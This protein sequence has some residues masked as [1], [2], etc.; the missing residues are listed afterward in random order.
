MRKKQL[1]IFVAI[2]CSRIQWGG[3]RNPMRFKFDIMLGR[4]KKKYSLKLDIETTF[5]SF[6]PFFPFFFL[7]CEMSHG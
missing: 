3:I 2:F 5:V 1:E 7:A 4:E 6:F